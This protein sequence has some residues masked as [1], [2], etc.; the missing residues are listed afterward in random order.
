MFYQTVVILP[1]LRIKALLSLLE[2]VRIQ[3][4]EKGIDDATL[5]AYRL[6]PDMLPFSRQIQIISDNAKWMA[7]RMSGV[8][9]PKY[10]DTEITLDDLIAR[11]EKLFLISV[12]LQKWVLIMPQML[13]LV[14]LGF[15]EKNLL[16]KDMFLL[17]VCQIS[18]FTLLQL[19]LFFVIMVFK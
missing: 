16:A 19:T 15:L 12:P 13:K 10:E 7:S 3:A 9:A 4:S 14:F 17:M 2:K 5:L 1:T 6:A 8:E 18:F 11:L